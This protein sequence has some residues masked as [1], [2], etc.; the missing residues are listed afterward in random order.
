MYFGWLMWWMV[1]GDGM[2]GGF[3]GLVSGWWVVVREFM[4]WVVV[5]WVIRGFM[6]WVGVWWLE[7]S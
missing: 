1:S 3:M 2:V 4:G 5:G 7:G 6:G